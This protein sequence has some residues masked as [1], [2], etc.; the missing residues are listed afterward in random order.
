MIKLKISSLLLLHL[1]QMNNLTQLPL[2]I[3]LI[4]MRVAHPRPQ[5][6]LLLLLL[7]LQIVITA[8]V[9]VFIRIPTTQFLPQVLHLP[10]RHRT[11]IQH[12]TH[13][14]LQTTSICVLNKHVKEHARAMLIHLILRFNSFQIFYFDFI[15]FFFSQIVVIY[16]I[17][18]IEIIMI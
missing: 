6:L 14:S 9:I 15:I 10:L 11:T 17:I 4:I 1:P 3:I 13:L 5:L 7:L 18:E 12:S 16:N 8:R 2:V